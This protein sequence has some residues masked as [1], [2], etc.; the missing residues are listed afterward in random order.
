MKLKVFGHL[1][2]WWYGDFNPIFDIYFLLMTMTNSS[3]CS[4]ATLSLRKW[5]G[6]AA[7]SKTTLKQV[8]NED[9]QIFNACVSSNCL[10]LEFLTSKPLELFKLLLSFP[11]ST[12]WARE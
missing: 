12:I 7:T 1:A 4:I 2:D 11:S 8:V 5:F 6:V 9:Q 3:R 10:F